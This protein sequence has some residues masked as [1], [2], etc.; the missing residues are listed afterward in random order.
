MIRKAKAVFRMIAVNWKLL[1][2]FELLYKILWAA[3]FLPLC[4]LAVNGAMQLTGYYYLTKNNFKSFIREPVTIAILIAMVLCLAFFLMVDISAILFILDQ[5]FQRRRVNIRHVLKYAIRNAARVLPGG[6]F[7][8]L[9]LTIVLLPFL[10]VSIIFSY[11]SSLPIAQDVL[12]IIRG[13][14]YYMAMIALCWLTLLLYSMRW[15]YSFHYFTLEKCSFRKARKRSSELSRQSRLRDFLTILCLQAVCYIVYLIF[16]LIMVLAAVLLAKLFHNL[17]LVKIV[18]T[19][20]VWAFLAVSFVIFA[21]L[22]TPISY[23]CISILF[24]TKKSRQGE[25]IIHYRPEHYIPDKKA[26]RRGRIVETAVFL[27]AIILCSLYMYDIS[28]SSADVRI[29]NVHMLEVTAHRG[30]SADYPENTMSAFTGAVALGADWIELDVQQTRDGQIIVMH[31]RNLLRTTGVRR[32]VWEMDYAQICQLDAGSWFSGKYEGERIPLLAEVVAFA[33]ENEIRL[34][35]ELKPTGKEKDFE[36]GVIDIVRAYDFQED[37]V[38]TSQNY[39]ALENVKAYDDTIETVYVMGFAYGNITKLKAADN[40]SI[41]NTS[42][43]RQLVSEVHNEGKQLYAWTVNSENRIVRMIDLN[44]DN[45]ITD[46]ITL[47]RQCI[48]ARKTSNMV[49]EF[50]KFLLKAFGMP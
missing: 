3:A 12:D 48:F 41:K 34:N 17:D 23:A 4:R 18:A 46:D 43:T 7:L 22:L 44:V 45:I 35:I 39:S 21:S 5:S 29:E 14:W 8:L 9:L 20:V 47:A 49:E 1:W 13:H 28:H 42:V 50:V 10:N 15:I 25:K 24:Y 40:F 31:D 36:K 19:S 38:I 30:A 2:E 26:E 33:R 37:C 32:N 16:A 6:N 27:A 11:I